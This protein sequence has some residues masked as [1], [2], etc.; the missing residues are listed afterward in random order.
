V[1]AT[2]LAGDIAAAQSLLDEAVR[3]GE[4]L[5]AAC[6]N[7]LIAGLVKWMAPANGNG[8][9]GGGGV[10]GGAVRGDNVYGISLE[11]Q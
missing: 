5:D 7:G 2:A 4:R 6:Y 9:G 10:N 1:R 11:D 3:D 8:G